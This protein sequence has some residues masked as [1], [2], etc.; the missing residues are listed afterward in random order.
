MGNISIILGKSGSGKSTS[1]K[2]LNPNESVVV[3]VLKKRLP[4]KGS[5]SIF[6][7]EKEN[8]IGIDTYDALI[9]FIQH[10]D[11]NMPNIKTLVV[12]DSIYVMRKE[13][14]KRA[15]EVGYTKF[16]ELAQ[17]FQQIIQTCE[18]ARDNLNVFLILHSE[19]VVS[20]KTLTGY[21]VAT[22]GTMIDNQYN[23]VEVV[24][25]VLY[26]EIRYDNNGKPS[27][28][29]YTHSIKVGSTQIPAKTPEGMFKDDYIPNDLGAVVKAIDEYYK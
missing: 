20:D 26:A 2:T 19:D 22:V 5:S 15:K 12:D 13:F 16:T 24:P 9:S 29:F 23:P 4:F 14:F 3:N 17:H 10:V 28:G 25:I 8:L 27:Y 6:N 7:E 1:I 18:N 11:A 21:K